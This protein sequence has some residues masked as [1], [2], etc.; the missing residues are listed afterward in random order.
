MSLK[1]IHLSKRYNYIAC[2]L[3]LDCNL[4]CHYC[5]NY[6]G[7]AGKF[8]RKIISGE[9]WV[10]GLNRIVCSRDL[11]V[12]LQGGEPSLHKDF[13]WIIKNI[14][15]DLNIDILTNLCFDVDEIIKNIDHLRLHRDAPYP[16]IRVS[17]HP[18]YMDLDELIRKVLKLQKVGFSIGIFGILHPEF[19]QEILEV[20]EKCRNLGIDFRTKE[21]LREYNGQ[22]YGTYLY[23]EAVG[24]GKRK[25]CLCRTSELIIG[26]NGNVYRCHHDLYKD[27]SPIGNLLDRNF[28]IEDIF[29]ECNQFG[30]CNPCDIKIKTNRFQVHGHTSVEI[31]DIEEF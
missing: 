8:K 28:E 22:I 21:F 12:T 9:K 11:P 15:P 16:N 3:T 30:D 27:F 24:N 2:F 10:E 29:R 1:R 14:R 25:R 4:G 19:E 13:I 23:P 18:Y 5:I 17:Y 31:K 26:P 6:F 7:G 20:Q